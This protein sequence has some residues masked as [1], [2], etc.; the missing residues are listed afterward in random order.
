MKISIPFSIILVIYL[1]S[2][3]KCCNPIA[4][5]S[6][7]Y[8]WPKAGYIDATWK[9]VLKPNALG[10][11]SGSGANNY[12]PL[13]IKAMSP[14][15]ARFN[16]V[17]VAAGAIEGSA[18][19]YKW[20]KTHPGKLGQK[21]MMKCG[22]PVDI[23][24]RQAIAFAAVPNAYPKKCYVDALWK[25]V[26]TPAVLRSGKTSGKGASDYM[27]K[28][29]AAISPK[30]AEYNTVRVEKGAINGSALKYKWNKS[31]SGK[32]GQHLQMRLGPECG[33]VNVNIT[34]Q[35][36][37]KQHLIK[38]GGLGFLSGK[39]MTCE[40]QDITNAKNLSSNYKGFSGAAISKFV[41]FIDKNIKLYKYNDNASYG[42]TDVKNVT[43]SDYV[44][45]RYLTIHFDFCGTQSVAEAIQDF[46]AIC[47]DSACKDQWLAKKNAVS[48]AVG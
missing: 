17:R 19:K 10:R 8:A 3:V 27:P 37:A 23:P 13:V 20:N 40:L 9:D 18:L 46:V 34:G 2:S 47:P 48:T 4:F 7:P 32:L 11:A 28:A 39:D 15:A 5:A 16:V 21:L 31:H 44:I 6:C 22:K 43:W 14:H 42:M 12:N 29:L 1:S 36:V 33:K 45:T 25:Y 38:F 35:Y 24:K 30:A 26:L 41:A